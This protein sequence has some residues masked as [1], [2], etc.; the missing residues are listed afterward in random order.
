MQTMKQILLLLG[1]CFYSCLLVAQATTIEQSVQMDQTIQGDSFFVSLPIS[2][3]PKQATPFILFLL[4]PNA[5]MQENR[6]FLEN[7]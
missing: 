7:R 2:I 4:I 1:S 6:Y 5:Q 3:T